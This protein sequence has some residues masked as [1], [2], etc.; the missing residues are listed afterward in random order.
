MERLQDMGDATEEFD[1]ARAWPAGARPAIK[2]P[3]L[4]AIRVEIEPLDVDDARVD[5]R[6]DA[7]RRDYAGVT[8]VDRPARAGDVV[9]ID[10]QAVIGEV[11]VSDGHAD[12]VAHQVGSGHVLDGLDEALIGMSAGQTAVIATRLVGGR[13]ADQRADLRIRLTTVFDAQIPDLDDEFAQLIAGTSAEQLRES[14]R[15]E[16]A[17]SRVSEAILAARDQ[18]IAALIDAV[19]PLSVDDLIRADAD[20][21]KQLLV[22]DLR[23]KGRSLEQYLDD[24]G[25]TEAEIDATLLGSAS[26]RLHCYMILDAIADQEGIDVGQN[27]LRAIVMDRADRSHAPLRAFVEQLVRTGM[28]GPIYVD[29]RRQ[30]ALV[31]VLRTVTVT[32][33]AGKTII[34]GG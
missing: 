24:E 33:T 19:G 1:S 11:Y 32:D 3:D 2:V 14:V 28:V 17:K 4:A 7:L 30:K 34:L 26:R 18:A 13:H 8:P 16:L 12:G 5:E 22:D 31:H 25:V 27:E 29:A 10:L 21:L 6:L 20:L 9:E 23:T 15:S